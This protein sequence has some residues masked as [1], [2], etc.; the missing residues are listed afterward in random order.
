MN[1]TPIQIR[2]NPPNKTNKITKPAIKRLAD[3]AGIERLASTTYD[4]VRLLGDDFLKQILRDALTY[5]IYEKRKTVSVEDIE[6]ALERQN[7]TV[8]K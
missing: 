2:R 6:R 8:Y 5:T 3:I 1:N 4:E 7:I